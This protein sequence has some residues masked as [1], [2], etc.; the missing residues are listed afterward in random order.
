MCEE[1]V[2][3]DVT[4]SQ[5]DIGEDD[6]QLLLARVRHLIDPTTIYLSYRVRDVN[7]LRCYVCGN[8]NE[9]R[10][11]VRYNYQC[12]GNSIVEFAVCDE[13]LRLS[14]RLHIIDLAKILFVMMSPQL[15]DDVLRRI[16]YLV[17]LCPDYRDTPP[18]VPRA[19][20]NLTLH[21]LAKVE[22]FSWS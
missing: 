4:L 22:S 5:S 17:W 21:V 8:A 2:G 7:S 11:R 13:C 18:T 9:H 12:G 19:T 15:L 16:L 3:T 14:K 1:C 6:S 10:V 20:R